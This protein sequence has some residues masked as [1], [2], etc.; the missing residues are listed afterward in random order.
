MTPIQHAQTPHSH[1]KKPTRR[2]NVL[3]VGAGSAGCVLANRLSQDPGCRVLLLESGPR[4]ASG[5]AEIAVRNG[6]QPAVVPGLN[7]KYKT[8]I[9]GQ[10]NPTD[11]RPNMSSVFHYE[12]G[13][14]VG[15]SSAVNATQA[16]RGSPQDYDDWAQDCG[17]SWSWSNVLPVFRALE[18]DPLGPSNLHGSGGAMPIRREPLEHIAPMHLSLMQVCNDAGFGTIAD[19]NDPATEGVGV[20]PRNVVDGV[21]VSASMAYLDPIESR[22]NLELACGVHVHRLLW[23]STGSCTGAIADVDGELCE[24]EA[25]VIALCAGVVST[26]AILLRSG[27]GDPA[28]LQALGIEVSLPLSGVGENFMD[29]P[30]VGIWGVPKPGASQMGEPLRQTLL[31]CT[32]GSA[33][34]AQDTHICLMTGMDPAAMFPHLVATHRSDTLAGITACFNRSTS[35]GRVGLTSADPHAAPWVLNNCLGDS[36][37]LGPMKAAVRLAWSLLHRPPLLDRFERLLAWTDGVVRSEAALEHA[38]RAFVRPSAHG[39]GTARMGR[40]P[41][42]GAVVDPH[43]RVHG[44]TNVWVADASVMP[45]IPTAP[46]HLSCLMVAERIANEIRQTL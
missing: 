9:K 41:Q 37:D 12:A 43:G 14:I 1:P 42:D 13:R 36:G 44:S 7:W 3:I 38:I 34:L 25:D 15:G 21:R 45:R 4:H 30:V 2:S 27:V 5:M 28:A 8:Q 39:C 19:H 32:L 26:P 23:S 6:N 31:R 10:S 33:A 11:A 46:P 16:L 18:D 17:P 35:R 24:F 22:P 40:S 20:I 29:H